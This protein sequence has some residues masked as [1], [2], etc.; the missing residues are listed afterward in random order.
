MREI[1]RAALVYQ[2]SV[3]EF[4]PE[5]AA[6]KAGVG[7]WPAIGS[8]HRCSPVIIFPTRPEP[9]RVGSHTDLHLVW[10]LCNA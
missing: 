10:V 9:L 6:P 8:L 7:G 3:R 4:P 5:F 1:R 2:G